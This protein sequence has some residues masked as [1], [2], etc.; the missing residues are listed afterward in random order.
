MTG[1]GITIRPARRSDVVEVLALTLQM[2]GHDGHALRAGADTLLCSTFEAPLARALVAEIAGRVVGYAELHARLS[3]FRGGREAW[4]SALVVDPGHRRTGIGRALLEGAEN[5]ACLL[6]CDSLAL[7]SSDW[8]TEAHGFYRTLGFGEQA[9]AV[10]FLK[11]TAY[12]PPQDSPDRHFLVAAA[13]ALSS[14]ALALSRIE[15]P[16][17]G[18]GA[19]G[20][21]T[22]G[23]DWSAESA[24]VAS[25]APL[26]LPIV[27]EE[28]GLFGG[29]LPE[30]GEAWICLDPLDGS[31]NQRAGMPPWSTAIGLVRDGK[32]IAGAVAEH[33]SGRRWWAAEGQGAWVDGRPAAPKLSDL[34]I[35]P[36]PEP[37]NFVG[38]LPG[39]SRIRISGSTAS[40][41]CRVADGSAAVFFGLERP[42]VHSH[43]LAGPAAILQ[44]AGACA[45]GIAGRTPSISADPRR[46][47]LVVAAYSDEEASRLIGHRP[48]LVN[49]PAPAR[50]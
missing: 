12:D 2:G 27:S 22:T 44:E 3:L 16:S 4:L 24:A 37:G 6:G 31:R 10:R 29:R 23:P 26:G 33:S 18:V 32:P 11:P 9:P 8:R 45:L 36:S 35:V 17:A 46:T 38:V 13:A 1:S 5:A 43:D 21:A 40:D 34:A 30:P 15:H 39:Y 47:Y 25:L 48:A 19:D 20:A 28:S 7:E 50:R 42:V 49:D 14:V 41:L